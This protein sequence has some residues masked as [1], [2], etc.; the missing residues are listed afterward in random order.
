MSRNRTV[1]SSAITRAVADAAAGKLIVNFY[2]RL[3]FLELWLEYSSGGFRFFAALGTEK[4]RPL[5]FPSYLPLFFEP[6]TP[7]HSQNSEK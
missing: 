1:S 5:K 7:P 4:W 6:N 2:R 3:L